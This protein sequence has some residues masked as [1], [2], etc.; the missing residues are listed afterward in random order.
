MRKVTFS[1]IVTYFEHDIPT[2]ECL[3]LIRLSRIADN[4][5]IPKTDMM[6]F[7]RLLR[8]VFG[9]RRQ[10]IYEDRFKKKK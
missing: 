2:I 10:I 9:E 5:I 8:P 7:E 4:H 6:R 1:S 3:Q